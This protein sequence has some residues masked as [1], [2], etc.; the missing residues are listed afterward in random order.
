MENWQLALVILT[1]VV[2]GAAIPVLVQLRFTL[3]ALEKTLETAGSRLDAA[4]ETTVG[5][6]RRIDSLVVRLEEGGRIEKLVDGIT[7]V[8][9]MAKDLRNTMRIASTVGAAVAPAVTAAV[10]AFRDDRHGASQGA[11]APEGEQSAALLTQSERRPPVEVPAAAADGG[12]QP[13][14]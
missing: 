1:A 2:V 8:T 6:A 7:T 10:H 11:V 13:S 12:P 9:S 4:L 14:G 5:A 3:R